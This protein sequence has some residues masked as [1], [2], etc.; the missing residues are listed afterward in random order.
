MSRR[1]VVVGGIDEAGLGPLLG[2]LTIGYSALELPDP[3]A[4][5]WRL[6]G[7]LVGKRPSK[8]RRLVVADSKRVFARNEPGRRR[9]EA[10]ALTFLALLDP[11]G[12]PPRDP[13]DLLFGHAPAPEPGLVRRHP[14]YDR[15]PAA[16]PLE[17]E[18]ASLELLAA[19]VSRR[20]AAKGLALVS[21]G[22]RVVPAGEL[23]ASYD[24]TE[25]KSLSVWAMTLEALRHLWE[26]HGSAG[27]RI[28]IDRQGG[29]LHYGPLLARGLPEAEVT[30]VAED[31]D[32]SRYRV[33]ARDRSRAMDLVIVEKAEERSFPVALA[34]CLAK[35]AREL[36][37][38][39]F[40]AYFGELQ[41]GLRPTAGY[42]S[43]GQR[44]LK[45]AAVALEKAA[46]PRGLV[47]RS[48]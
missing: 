5:P 13:R 45:E 17:H 42:F 29:R 22:V 14:W 48:R 40:N 30:L 35:Y 18:A 31:E 47:V 37:M 11:K 23:N 46:L 28:T 3:H 9:L 32:G 34:S 2:P 4:N 41:P 1:P 19:L 6:L 15:L 20:M 26:A 16:L 24:A 33:V 25:N 12:R 27:P 44:W 43:D 36:V 7:N 39:A 10:T 38:G 21:A 8:H